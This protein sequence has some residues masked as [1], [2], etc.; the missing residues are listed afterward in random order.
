MRCC[1][2]SSTP[3]RLTQSGAETQRRQGRREGEAPEADAGYEV[4][5]TRDERGP[6]AQVFRKIDVAV[7]HVVR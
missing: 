1:Y 5:S 3:N 2:E 4:L 6:S 7:V